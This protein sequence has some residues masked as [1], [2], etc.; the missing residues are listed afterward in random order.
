MLKP[1]ID[2]G[3][4]YV[5]KSRCDE[6]QRMND[7]R[8]GTTTQRGY[9]SR[10]QHMAKSYLRNHRVCVNCG[11]T[12]DLTVDHIVP[13]ARGGLNSTDNMQTLCRSCNSAK[14]DR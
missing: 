8:R 5:V 7:L 1:C 3:V 6:C 9:G 11:A 12:T 2:C 14:R 13:L 10:W 4:E